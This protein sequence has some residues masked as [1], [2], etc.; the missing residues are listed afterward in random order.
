IAD[1]FFMK[2]RASWGHCYECSNGHLDLWFYVKQYNSIQVEKCSGIIYKNHNYSGHQ[3]FLKRGDYPDSQKSFSLCNSIRS[4]HVILQ[5]SSAWSVSQF[6][7]YEKEELQGQMLE[8]TDDCPAVPGC[9]HLPEIC[10]LNALGHS[11]ILYEMPNL[12]GQQYLLKPREY[13]RFL[14]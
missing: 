4:Y 7:L 8:L 3:Y 6:Q 5:E 11:W 2:T 1:H 12:R 13:R 9:I 10:S 14:D